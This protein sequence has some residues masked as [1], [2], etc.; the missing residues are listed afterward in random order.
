MLN[1]LLQDFQSCA[2]VRGLNVIPPLLELLKS[3]YPVIQLLALKTLEVISKDTETRITLG[4]NKGLECLL[5]IL[6]TNVQFTYLKSFLFLLLML[7]D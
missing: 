7:Y 6:E 3:E 5:K 1:I 2:A 4:E